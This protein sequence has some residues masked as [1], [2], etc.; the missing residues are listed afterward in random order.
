MSRGHSLLFIV[1]L[2]LISHVCDYVLLL[3]EVAVYHIC[4]FRDKF[5]PYIAFKSSVDSLSMDSSEYTNFLTISKFQPGDLLFVQN[6]NWHHIVWCL[7]SSL[8]WT[9]VTTL[10]IFKVWGLA[11]Y[12]PKK[13]TD[14]WSGCSLSS[15]SSVS[16]SCWSPS[17]PPMITVHMRTA[18]EGVAFGCWL[19]GVGLSSSRVVKRLW[20]TIS[21]LAVYVW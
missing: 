7:S 17:Y 3:Q 14:R 5:S 18:T 6:R 12:R 8:K 4:H 2:P 20:Q 13:G 9:T 19:Y 11:A 1:I 10:Y 15:P 16:A 21:G